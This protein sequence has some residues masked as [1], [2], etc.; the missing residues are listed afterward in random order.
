MKL[1]IQKLFPMTALG[2][3]AAGACVLAVATLVSGQGT[4]PKK[5]TRAD[6]DAHIVKPA[7]LEATSDRVAGLKSPEGFR[8]APFATLQNPRMMAVTPDGTV[9]VSQREPGNLVM[10]KD[11]NGD[12]VADVKKIVAERKQLHGLALRGNTL[13]FT[14]V[15]EVLSARIKPDGTLETPRLLIKDLPDGGQHPNRTIAFDPDGMLYISVG[16]TCNA[17]EETS[18]ESATMLRANPDG[19]NRKIY[20]SG[21]RNTIGFGW[22]P[23]SKR[24]WGFDHGIDWLGDDDQKEE[25][26]EI[27]GGRRYGWP[28]V[29]ADGK[30]NLADDPPKGYTYESWAKTSR[31]PD[32]LYTA[33]SAPLQMAFYAGSQ[34]PAEYKNDAFVAMRGSWN[35]KPPSGYEVV[36]VKFDPTGK[37]VSLTPFL[38]GFLLPGGEKGGGDDEVG[39]FA[40]LAGV[41]VAKDGALLV[42]DD[43]NGVIYRVSYGGGKP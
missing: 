15:K 31:E 6:I 23:T 12:G 21:L 22:H 13:Y 7:L 10:L 42:G 3:A 18:E 37:P 27:V 30:P 19:T 14:T 43:T 29:F 33:H 26:N 16:S 9:Y 36:R 25:L 11:T 20:A 4:P 34:F 40:R 17:C 24:M 1:P 39:H 2:G 35:R 28:Y 8:I 38:T 32:L 5:T 41:A